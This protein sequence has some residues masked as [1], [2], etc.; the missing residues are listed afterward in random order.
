MPSG[1]IY[2]FLYEEMYEDAIIKKS[3]RNG[4]D[5]LVGILRT[6]NLFPIHPNAIKIAESVIELYDSDDEGSVELFFNDLDFFES[7]S[8]EKQ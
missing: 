7:D 4:I 5:D 8:D 2:T 1:D 3:I 6:R